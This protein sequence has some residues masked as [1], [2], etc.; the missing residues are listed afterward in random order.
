MLLGSVL[1][2]VLLILAL[3]GALR[4]IGLGA[5]D[6]AHASRLKYQQI[7]LPILEPGARPDGTAVLRTVDTRLP[8]QE[9]LAEKPANALRIFTFGGSATAGL[10]FS[11]NVTFAR[12]L[13][14]MLERAYPD[15]AVEVV[16]LG[17]VAIAA[18]QVEVLVEHVCRSYEPDAVVVYSGNN[19]FLEIHA[20]KYA[21]ANA[22]AFTR[23]RDVVVQTNL[24]RLVDRAVR[25][26]PKAP[27]MAD[28]D[29]SQDD[30]RMTQAQVIQDIEMN[31]DE[32]AEIVD[33]YGE[34]IGRVAAV[35]S[36][37]KTP[38]VLM[39]V[40]SNWEWRGREDLAED[41]LDEYVPDDGE[42]IEDRYR[43]ALSV[44]AAK[45]EEA[46]AEERSALHFAR[47]VAADGLGDYELARS[48]YRTA[49][50]IDPHL[51]RALD[52][53]ADEVRS[54]AKENES[55]LVD[56]I[57]VLG[58]NA[59]RGSVG[60]DEF[61]DYVHFT[62]RAVVIVAAAVFERM[63]ADGILPPTSFDPG[64]YAAERL[65]LEASLA[66]DLLG[67]TEWLGFGFDTVNVADR[68][69]WKYDR[70]V[71]D[72][73]ARI[74]ANP[75]E[76]RPLVY[77]GNARFFKIGGDERAAADYEAALALEP[78]EA[79]VIRASLERL[80]AQAR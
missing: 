55:S 44:L 23:F 30:L 9:I 61:Y 63:L 19:E 22:T 68:D 49:M 57:E 36:A 48:E 21:S 75:N 12:H 20:E 14:R 13:E 29:F 34:T 72:L 70:F 24:F 27:S 11:P 54:V 77:R 17:I 25:G 28:E 18:R 51:R 56:V 3:E 71:K 5:P 79:D 41:W 2:S 59:D 66:E 33:G 58:A 80:E 32:I 43:Q 8:Y 78:G 50:N 1:M 47:A 15:R 64:T 38:L 7:Y 69:L 52:V 60:H 10:G 42:A 31:D 65:A 16:N 26:A 45:L 76:V 37:T 73:D 39:T 4:L 67:V 6:A 40:A 35:A 46:G 53:M 74:E 62:P